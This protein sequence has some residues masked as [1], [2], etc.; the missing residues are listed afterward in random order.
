VSCYRQSAQLFKNLLSDLDMLLR[1]NRDFL[2][3]RWLEAAKALGTTASVSRLSCH[4]VCV[5]S[6]DSFCSQIFLLLNMLY[7]YFEVKDFCL[8]DG[9]LEYNA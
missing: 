1:S 2:L 9:M 6:V 7:L 4:S 5:L 8:L 3:G